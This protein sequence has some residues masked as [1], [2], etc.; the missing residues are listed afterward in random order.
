M[1]IKV[2]RFADNGDTTMGIFLINDKF[3]CFTIE[4]EGRE[5][6]V[7]GETRIPEGTYKVALRTEGGY[8]KRYASKYGD[9]HKGML[10]IYNAEDWKIVNAGM[11]F[12]YVLIH[13]G[14]TDEHTMGCLLVN[15]G[16][17]GDNYVGNS[18]VNAYKKIYPIIAHAIL[19]GETVTIEYIDIE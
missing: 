15:D 11:E 10:A 14:N 3:Y 17:D 16:L 2:K 7:K 1:E 8:H 9:M 12:Q 6:K 18:S 19:A 4:D 5:T 13:T